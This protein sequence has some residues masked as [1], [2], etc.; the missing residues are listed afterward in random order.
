MS[1]PDRTNMLSDL[2]HLSFNGFRLPCGGKLR[3]ENGKSPSEDVASGVR[4]SIMVSSADRAG[5]LTHGQACDA[6]RAGTGRAATA[7]PGGAGFGHL[8]EPRACVIAFVLQH[9][10]HRAPARV[11]HAF[12]VRSARERLR[13]HIPNTY[14]T[15]LAY[16]ASSELV[17][18]VF[19][20]ITDLG[21]D[22][23][24]PFPVACTLR[25][26]KSRLQVAVEPLGL[27]FASIAQR[28]QIPQPEIDA[29]GGA[30]GK[31]SLAPLR[32]HGDVQIPAPARILAEVSRAKL[33]VAQPPAIPHGQP[34]AS[35]VDL[36]VRIFDGADFER[37]PAERTPSAL[38]LAP[39]QA[40]FAVLLAASCILLRSLLNRLHRKVERIEAT[41]EFTL[42]L[43][44]AH[45]QFIAVIPN[46]VDLAREAFKP[47]GMSILHP[48][49]QDTRGDGA[50]FHAGH[51]SSVSKMSL[52]SGQMREAL[53]TRACAEAYLPLSPAPAFLRKAWIGS[54]RLAQQMVAV[55]MLWSSWAS[56]QVPNDGEVAIRQDIPAQGATRCVAAAAQYHAVNP[57]ALAAILKVESG[58]NPG[59][60][61]R[62]PNNTVDVGMAQINSMHFAE[63]GRY[64]IAPEKLMDGC[65][66]TYVAAWHLAKQMRTYG[67]TWFGIGS[68]HSATPCFNT[69]YVGLVWNTLVDWRAVNGRRVKV[70][71]L[72][73]CGFPVQKGHG[74]TAS[75]RAS[76]GPL[77]FDQE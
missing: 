30:V 5:P 28:G 12:G 24:R 32:V 65:V 6:L 3:L 60:V 16:Q 17:Q 36:P 45:L 66:A 71:S 7:H 59:A 46:H 68:Y 14:D 72:Q 15:V 47:L 21:V 18:E 39:G 63:L 13:I 57:W 75:R 53:G 76:T 64:G 74:T 8:D 43:K 42:A 58:F 38:A 37:Q 62:N 70:Q 25:D 2:I 31:W 19:S 52:I 1:D 33:V 73:D 40:H 29:D 55:T 23:L 35:V 50:G 77:A 69:R 10:S 48:D 54:G 22:R 11:Q 51:S 41:E 44:D 26:G 67:N 20:A 27:H 34:L 61:N 4:V 9:G 56:A 49:A